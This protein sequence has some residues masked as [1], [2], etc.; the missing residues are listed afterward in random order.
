MAP[1]I[2]LSKGYDAT[3][4]IYSLG[5][6]L[7]KLLNNNRLPF[8]DPY[9][10]LLAY[11]DRRTAIG[12]RLSGEALPPPVEASPELAQIIL[13]AC[14]FDPAMRF[15]TPTAFKNALG[16]PIG[17]ASRPAPSPVPVSSLDETVSVRRAPQAD[18]LAQA[19]I[20]VASFGKEKKKSNAKVFAIAMVVLLS[21]GGSVAGYHFLSPGGLQGIV[22]NVTGGNTVANV[23]AA[24]EAGEYAEALALVEELDGHSDTIQSNLQSS[25]RDRLRT[26]EVDFLSDEMEYAV[27]MMELNTIERMNISGLSSSI[28]GT[29][30]TVNRLN[31]S[32]TAFNTAESLYERGNYAA[33][34]TQYIQVVQDDPN[35]MMATEGLIR[36]A[37]AHR[38][39][40]LAHAGNYSGGGD[41]VRA[42]RV[43]SDA[44]LVLENDSA[45][46]Q[47]LN[48]YRASHEAA[49]RQAILDTAHEYAAN[50]HWVRAIVTLND[51]LRDLPGDTLMT[52][53]LRSYEALYIDEAI[54][55]ANAFVANGRFND[56]VDVLNSVL[57]TLPNNTQLM[58]E[59]DRV[60]ALRPVSLAAVAIVEAREYFH[61]TELFADSFGN[62]HRE[63]HRF[64]PQ[65]TSGAHRSYSAP[66]D[67]AY[68]VYNLNGNF[69]TFSADIV[70]PARLNH[71]VEFLITITLDNQDEPILVV[72]RFNSRTI[73]RTLE[74]DVS[75]V[76]TMTI[77]VRVR[78]ADM[79]QSGNHSIHLVNTVLFPADS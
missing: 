76:T 35:Y 18:N 8:L 15:Q 54:G 79:L 13:T 72:E 61:N 58:E 17:V 49:N 9:T 43:L 37:D 26:L 71:W 60:E 55:D 52:E 42:I 56:A 34:I 27:V 70:A 5:L 69:K 40:T 31:A 28:T 53:R 20:P 22:S 25:L 66:E 6:V 14:A 29:R 30:D 36:A 63:S 46:T 32:R 19:G 3:V 64:N 21:I 57:Q 45:L 1:E 2:E 68:V 75:G 16:S 38:T 39:A 50:S 4:D 7:Y 77:T 74:L 48:I 33:A 59:V 23:I 10:Q 78:V 47:Q 62:E 73:A 41:Y 44:L 65:I 24:L 67:S 51:G 12:R 11:Q